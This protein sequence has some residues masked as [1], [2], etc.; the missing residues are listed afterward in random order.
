MRSWGVNRD[1]ETKEQGMI[2]AVLLAAGKSERMGK[3]KQL[4]SIN[5][6]T[7]VEACADNLLASRADEVVVVTGHNQAAVRAALATRPVRIVDNPDYER[8]MASSIK[9]GVESAAGGARA[10][11]IGLSD[12]PLIG[13]DVLN[14]IIA[15]YED[16]APLIVIPTYLGRR[17]HPILLDSSLRGEIVSMDL[18]IG[19]SQVT[20]AHDH[21]IRYVEVNSDSVLMDFDLPQ[22]LE[23]LPTKTG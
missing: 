11:L 14:Q 6:K 18:D 9:R 23:Q 1:T 19:L 8:G 15:E 2:S 20:R 5:G 4:L 3:F 13:P 12:Q 22:D 7:F 10:I 21:Q 16:N 17:G